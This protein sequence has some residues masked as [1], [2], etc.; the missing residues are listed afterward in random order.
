MVISYDP[1]TNRYNGLVIRH[2]DVLVD[3][4]NNKYDVDRVNGFILMLH[5]IDK[6]GVSQIIS[7]SVDPYDTDRYKPLTKTGENI[8]TTSEAIKFVDKMALNPPTGTEHWEVVGRRWV[9]FIN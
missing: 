1:Q 7:V 8:Y 4:K 2:G 6:K 5:F 9:K 3:S